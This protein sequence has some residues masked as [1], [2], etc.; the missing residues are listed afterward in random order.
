[1]F[2]LHPLG[3]QLSGGD[4]IY[5][6][7]NHEIKFFNC[8]QEQLM[9]IAFARF[10][11]YRSEAR[12]GFT[13]IDLLAVIAVIAI[14]VCLRLSAFAN[15]KDRTHMVQCVDNLRQFTTGTLIYAEEN[16]GNM[17][18]NSSS[19]W[20]WDISWNLGDAITQFVSWKALY[21]PAS[22]FDENQNGLLWN[23]LPGTMHVIGYAQTFP[24]TSSLNAENVNFGIA[25]KSIQV[26]FGLYYTPI[27]SERVLFADATMSQPGESNESL[28]NTYSYVNL[29]GAYR[30]R[31][32]HMNGMLPAGGNLA[33]L[34]GH[35]EWR[36][37]DKMHVRTEGFSGAPVYWW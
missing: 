33:M 3:C 23:Y 37:F 22:G 20:D 15:A 35:V 13:L 29:E 34:D 17:P 12:A 10:I 31:T 8:H 26:G 6:F 11:A 2:A 9:K 1:M 30:H 32:S 21:C 25:P 27:A 14:L 4:S 5:K 19:F 24:K 18:T 28:R 36:S 16:N 7:S